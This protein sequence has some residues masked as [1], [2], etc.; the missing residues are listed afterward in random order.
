MARFTH[1]FPKVARKPVAVQ[2]WV[3][4]LFVGVALVTLI[5]DGVSLSMSLGNGQRES[6]ESCVVKGSDL[7]THRKESPAPVGIEVQMRMPA[8]PVPDVGP[9]HRDR[10]AAGVVLAEHGYTQ[11]EIERLIAEKAVVAA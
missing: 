1:I 7:D 11:G 6:L 10:Q 9:M 8:G 5:V 2:R 3:L 4:G